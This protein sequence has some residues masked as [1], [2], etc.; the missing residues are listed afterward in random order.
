MIDKLLHFDIH[1]YMVVKEDVQMLLHIFRWDCTS[2]HVHPDKSI[3]D[4]LVPEDIDDYSDL[5]DNNLRLEMN[6]S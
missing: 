2:D 1:I 4:R 5:I 6:K 3:D